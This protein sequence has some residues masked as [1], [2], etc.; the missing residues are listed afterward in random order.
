MLES[1]LEKRVE[2]REKLELLIVA[3]HCCYNI[4]VDHRLEVC[5]FTET[6]SKHIHT[7]FKVDLNEESK[8]KLFRLMDLSLIVH[9]PMLDGD[10]V[11]LKYV[12]DV[13]LWNSQLRNFAYIV[14]LELKP[15]PK[16][17]YRSTTKLNINQVLVQFAARLSYLVYWDELVWQVDKNEEPTTSKRQRRSTKLQALIDLVTPNQEQAE[18]N[19]KWLVVTAEVIY[20]YPASLQNED[21]QV[22]LQAISQFQAT[23]EGEIQVY[24]FTKCCFVLL[25]R[26]PK[27]LATANAI[28]ANLCKELWNKIADG[29]A[30]VCSL[31]NKNSIENHI[32]LQVLIHHHKYPSNSFIENIINIFLSNST[33]KCDATLQTLVTILSSFNLDTLPNGKNLLEKIIK[34]TFEKPSLANLKKVITTTG[35]EKP[36]AHMLA[37]VG[38]ICCLSQTDFVN[39]SKK[40]QLNKNELF[41]NNWNI[42]VQEAYKK[43]IFRISHY[44]LVKHNERLL[45]EEVDF[46]QRDTAALIN[47]TKEHIPTEIKC[48]IEPLCFEILQSETN[49]KSKVIDEGNDTERIKDYL[50]QVL[51]NNEIMMSL[52]D[53]FLTF[54]AFNDEKLK[55]SFILKKVD[56]HLQ[57]IERLFKL[58]LKKRTN[59]EMRDTHELLLL[60][61]SMF[62]RNLHQAI[63]SKVRTFDLTS[64]I[65]WVSNQA[66]HN[67]S[68]SVGDAQL[69]NIG[70]NEFLEAKLDEKMKF[71]AIATL[72]EYNNLPGQNTDL[73]KEL[74]TEIE[75]DPD[76]NMDLHSIFH[77]IK[78]LGSQPIK[79]IE[80][81][82]WLWGYIVQICKYHHN[83][84]Y[85]SKQMIESF[86]NI[87][88]FTKSFSEMA[89]NV[90][91]LYSS[92]AQIC[93]KPQYSS[94]VSVEFIRQFKVFHQVS[95]VLKCVQHIVIHSYSFAELFFLFRRDA[96]DQNV[97]VLATK[98]FPQVRNY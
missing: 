6:I 3:Y 26:E 2:S 95:F 69:M 60:V 21:Y 36:S 45:I 20:N 24:A 33:I 54:E 55:G 82:K 94:S 34:Y 31:N 71:L 92:F 29:T 47:A 7:V 77:A 39:F 25:E 19:W 27:F 35:K 14:D 78:V 51:E 61:K 90:I 67:F 15:T 75:L 89:S 56:Y 85:V 12:N 8:E 42:K 98:L 59:L 84:Q 68:S 96:S 53:C 88:S 9:Y 62:S 10:A 23:M 38:V 72:F 49:F 66:D 57:E 32:A 86:E 1:L 58:I 83:N 87:L 81:V 52:V 80:I 79:D 11:K 5:R 91:S 48:I 46:K 65:K 70:P 4:A 76:D 17:K 93:C 43:D 64:C 97:S 37:K 40:S 22:L 16:T 30:R 18:F 13:A 50:L 74:I 44:I 63:C 73:L 41:T 28:I